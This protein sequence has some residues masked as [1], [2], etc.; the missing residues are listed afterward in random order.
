MAPPSHYGADIICGDLQP[1][2]IHMNYGGGQSG[3][4]IYSMKK[5]CNG[6]SFKIIWSCPY[7]VEGEYGFGDVAYDRT[8]FGNLREKGKEFVGT[9]HPYGQLQLECIYH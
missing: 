7:N 9:K 1:L 5:I 4:Y 8:S 3:F 6:V 2:G